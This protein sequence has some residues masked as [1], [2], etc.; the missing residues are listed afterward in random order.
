MSRKIL[1][2]CGIIS[3]L[4]YAGLTGFLPLLFEGYDAASQTIS[5]LSAIGAPTR[6]VW[7]GVAILY[8]LLFAAFGVGVW[9]SATNNRRLRIA[10]ILIFVYV[11]FNFYWPPMHLRGNQPGLTDTLHIAW[12]MVT[13]IL[14]ML[15]MGFGAAALGASFR[16]YTIVTFLIF[17]LFGILI[18]TE[19]P[20]IA[21][22]LPTPKIGVW[23]RVNVGAFMLWV[24]VFATV[25]MKKQPPAKKP[26]GDS[27]KAAQLET[28]HS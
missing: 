2:G 27:T 25:L 13:I 21:K 20:L 11:L 22:N 24:I 18:S 26:I 4:L 17:L 23:E 14:M 16:V 1:L 15:I 8:I 12:A 6:S 5:E 28:Q 7:V 3:S 9:K 10:A 19:A